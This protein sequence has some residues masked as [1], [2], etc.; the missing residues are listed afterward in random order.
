M[1]KRLVK[2][3]RQENLQVFLVE[4]PFAT[5]EELAQK[6]GCSIQTIRLD[7]L[8]LG[9][10]EVRERMK[11]VAEANYSIVKSVTDREIIGELI[12]L[13]LGK[14]ATSILEV[15]SEMVAEKSHVCRGHH[16]F[17]QANMLAVA[18]IDAEIV[19]TGSA[20]IRYRRPV[21]LNEK[22]I[23]TAVLARQRSNKHLVKVVSKVGAEE[24]FVGKFIVVSR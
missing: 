12:E 1:N 16:I 2:V 9:I 20:R 4:N 10:P 3:H 15:T 6:F 8:E 23:A 5:D 7:R 24:V 17:S 14:K 18:L 11:R 22:L 13:D 19:L 21:Y